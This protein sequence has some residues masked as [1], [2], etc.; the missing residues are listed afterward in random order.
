MRSCGG[1][2]IGEVLSAN[3]GENE[4]LTIVSEVFKDSEVIKERRQY[5]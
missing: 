4:K 1:N 3:E 2:Y 5:F